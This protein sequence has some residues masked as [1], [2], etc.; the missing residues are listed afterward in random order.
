MH[1]LVTGGCG[2][3]GSHLVEFLL[4]NGHKVTVIDDLSTGK[5]ENIPDSASLIVAGIT[6]SGIFD[7]I[8]KSVDGCFHLAAIVSVQKST[9]DWLVTHKVNQSGT[10]ALLAAITK[11]KRHIPVVYASSAAAYGNCPD[12]PLRENAACVPTSA[13]GVDKLGCEWQARIASTIHGI[14]T[15]GL[16]FFNVYGPRQEPD[17]PYSGVISIF[18]N[19]MKQGLP[20]TIYGDGGQT[21]DFVYVGDIVRG[22]YMSMGCLQ[23]KER[24]YG[25]YNLCTG[26]QTS[27]N[28]LAQ[29]LSL[30]TRTEPAITN[31]PARAGDIR[32]S[33]GNPE[34]SSKEI[35]FYAETALQAGLQKTLS[36]L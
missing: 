29:I 4:K 18:A 1:Y 6:V 27:I 12:V 13:Y 9:E 21:R 10:V 31:A 34:L 25:I 15:T 36:E 35:G 5:R 26:I 17:S 30:A 20:I 28:R 23:R 16:R 7:E 32:F 22:L 11:Q 24:I 8:I 19:R 2:F 14:P 33:A 3:I